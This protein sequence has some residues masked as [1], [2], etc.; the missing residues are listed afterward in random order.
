MTR[1]P[2]TSRKAS[3]EAEF[4]G[5]GDPHRFPLRRNQLASVVRTALKEDQAFDDI[6]TIA[7]VASNRR[8]RGIIV[9]RAKG[10]IAGTPL[11]VAA[12]RA[13]DPNVVV[14]VD[15][16]DG[17]E[18]EP[19]TMIMFVSG[20]ARALLSLP[21]ARQIEL[22]RETAARGL[23]VR[24]VE[25]RATAV[26]K[27]PRGTARRRQ[28]PDVARLEE[29]LSGRL[30]TSVQIKSGAKQGVGSLIIR[31]GSLDQLDALLAKLAS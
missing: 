7:T 25:R 23:S 27:P 26:G 28:D 22:A 16:E 13:L 12:F 3:E 5:D 15:V 10:V 30:G 1:S 31:Y 2:Q 20:H 6:T 29:E 11:A 24:D 17:G 8:A 14:R 18:V 4:V 19:G 9:A 21:V